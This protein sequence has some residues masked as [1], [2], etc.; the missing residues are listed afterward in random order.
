M[1][2][3][4]KPKLKVVATANIL[5]D[6]EMVVND[7]VLNLLTQVVHH[8]MPLI[9]DDFECMAL[10]LNQTISIV[11]DY[12][13]KLSHIKA[14]MLVGKAFLKEQSRIKSRGVQA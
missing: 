13:P 4:I 12:L 7:E 9:D 8:Y 14:S 3:E 11:K 10:S 1:K 5:S 2:K 6:D